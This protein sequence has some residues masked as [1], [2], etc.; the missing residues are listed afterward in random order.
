MTLKLEPGVKRFQEAGA[1]SV[2]GIWDPVGREKLYCSPALR[3]KLGQR[4]IAALTESLACWLCLSIR[5][6]GESRI[7]LGQR[8]KEI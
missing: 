4:G 1:E 5:G 8:R 6:E 3:Y 2:S 7:Y